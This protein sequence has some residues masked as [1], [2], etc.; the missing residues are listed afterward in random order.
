MKLTNLIKLTAVIPLVILLSSCVGQEPNDIAYVTA[1]GIDKKDDE[2]VY[3]IQFANPTKI[4][5]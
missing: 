2:Y 4:S 5:G 1:L 3:T